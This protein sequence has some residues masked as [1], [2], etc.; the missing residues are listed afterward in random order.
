MKIKM[1]VQSITQSGVVEGV[2]TYLV[3]L[4]HDKIK[5]GNVVKITQDI[6]LTVTKE[7]ARSYFAGELQEI[8]IKPVSE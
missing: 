6:L 4:G 8:E 2:Q 1:R 3:R 5:E 7:G